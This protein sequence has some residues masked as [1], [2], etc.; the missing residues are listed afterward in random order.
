MAQSSSVRHK[1]SKL[2]NSFSAFEAWKSGDTKIVSFRGNRR[3]MVYQA[4]MM[5]KPYQLRTHRKRERNSKE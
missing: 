4:Q 2:F 5:L 3:E 1:L